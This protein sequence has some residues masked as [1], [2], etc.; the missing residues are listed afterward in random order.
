MIKTVLPNVK[1]SLPNINKTVV[2]KTEIN[3]TASIGNH[4]NTYFCSVGLA[5][6]FSEQNDTDHHKFLGKR[7]LNSIYLEQTF[8][9]EISKRSIH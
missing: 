6:K 8:P 1:E 7:I 9:Q 3:D 4:F 5:M 2:N